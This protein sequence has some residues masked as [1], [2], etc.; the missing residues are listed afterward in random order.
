MGQ[1]NGESGVFRGAIGM[2]SQTSAGAVSYRVAA[3]SLVAGQPGALP[4]GAGQYAEL[5][6][7]QDTWD[8]QKG[9]EATGKSATT[10]RPFGR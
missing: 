1:V 8:G 2:A 5:V 3:W 4:V 10:H 7:T 9:V 6:R